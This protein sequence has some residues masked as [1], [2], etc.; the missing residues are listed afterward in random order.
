MTQI[1]RK[2]DMHKNIKQGHPSFG[3][4]GSENGCD[5]VQ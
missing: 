1:H 5:I 3:T 4:N 2:V